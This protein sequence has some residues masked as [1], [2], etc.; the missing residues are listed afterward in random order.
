M[1]TRIGGRYHHH[2]P[3][4]PRQLLALLSRMH[5]NYVNDR[6]VGCITMGQQRRVCSTW[7]LPITLTRAS[8]T[9]VHALFHSPP[10]PS[11]STRAAAEARTRLLFAF[12]SFGG[13]WCPNRNGSHRGRRR[14]RE[15]EDRRRNKKR[16]DAFECGLR[17]Q[18]C[19]PLHAQH[20]A[21]MDL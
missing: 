5:V 19:V 12:F 6:I 18:S 21:F 9:K 16:L 17:S 2:Q 14:K 7:T 4:Q 10:A 8:T 13:G 3:R 11:S 20:T 1:G 15:R